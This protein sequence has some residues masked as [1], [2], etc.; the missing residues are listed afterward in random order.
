M[1][2]MASVRNQ[3]TFSSMARTTSTALTAVRPQAAGGCDHRIPHHHA[4]CK[5][6]VRRLLGS[7]TNIITRSG[8]NQLH[9]ALWEFLRNDAF[10]ASNYFAQTQEPLKQNQFGATTGGPIRKDK[11]FIFGYYEG[12][13]NRQGVTALTTVPSVKERTGNF[14]ELCPEGFTNGFCNN[15]GN[16][17]FNIFANAPYPNNQVPSSQF[18]PISQ[19]LLQYFPLPNV[20]TNLFSASRVIT[21]DTNQFGIKIDDYLTPTNTLNF[22]YMFFQLSQLG[23]LSPQG[24]S[25]PGFPVGREPA[26]AE[27]CRTRYARLLAKPHRRGAILVLA[28]QVSLR[29][30]SEP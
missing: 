12:F 18:N 10:D 15:P 19:N 5:C 4:Q 23:P 2:S 8:T 17:L 3:T 13:R 1:R 9:G 22:R 25:V 6:R 7:T 21:N 26:R 27:L 11:A 20:G 16:Q 28:Q 24:A 29:R 30:G 14:S